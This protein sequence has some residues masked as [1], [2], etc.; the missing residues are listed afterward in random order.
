MDKRRVRAQ[1]P[2]LRHLPR[3]G[4]KCVQASI[5]ANSPHFSVVGDSALQRQRVPRR[6]G[7]LFC[8]SPITDVHLVGPQESGSVVVLAPPD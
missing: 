8:P 4:Q 2:I 6:R 7:C 1:G 5:V 3:T